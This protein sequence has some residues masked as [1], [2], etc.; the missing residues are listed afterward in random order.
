MLL[1][2]VGECVQVRR[3]VCGHL[4]LILKL[5]PVGLQQRN[6]GQQR[7]ETHRGQREREGMDDYLLPAENH[8]VSAM[9]RVGGKLG[10]SLR[11]TSD[12]LSN[13]RDLVETRL[14]SDTQLRHQMDMA[15]QMMD[16]W[17][18]AAAVI[19]RICFIIFSIVFVI[20]TVVLF[21]LA[22]SV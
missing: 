9:E 11:S 3:Y 22:T 2:E 16:E 14:R 13:I 18:I 19:D 17:M 7:D 8:D 5:R 21:V 10:N 6:K 12:V 4:A 20:G 1:T 15:Q